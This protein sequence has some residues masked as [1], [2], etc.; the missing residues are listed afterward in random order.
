MKRGL[1]FLA[2]L[3]IGALFLWLSFRHVPWEKLWVYMQG[4]SFGWILPFLV[5]ALLSHLIRA[6][7]WKMLIERENVK[8]DLSD[9]YAAV[10]I[11][12][13]VNYAVPRLGEISRCIYVSRRQDQSTSSLIGTVIVERAVDLLFLLLAIIF[14]VGY[15][16]TDPHTIHDLFGRGV[17]D[18]FRNEFQ[19]ANPLVIGSLVA[20]VISVFF[21]F[22]LIFKWL[23][24]YY[25]WMD[26]I[27][28]KGMDLLR[29]VWDGI[30]GIS[31]IQNWPLFLLLSLL[32]WFCYVLM[33]YIPFSMFHM[34]QSYHLTLLDA[35][36]ITVI[37]SIGLT[38]PTP[39]GMG[40]Y[41]WFVKQALWV[42]YGIPQ[43]TG[44][45]YAFI[46]YLTAMLMFM[47]FTPIIVF[48]S[49][50]L[51]SE[52]EVFVSLRKLLKP[53]FKGQEIE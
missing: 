15:V 49:R 45:A 11:G 4:M 50:A 38:L 35:L 5:I 33:T 19:S 16:V 14:V 3:V 12:Y 32:M 17:F 43:V 7:R 28:I 8:V 34:I 52:R 18:W 47:V 22:Y 42:L 1:Q 25:E 24:Q 27:R 48:I 37:A 23:G 30:L 44:L 2:S 6:M 20:L 51:H 31:R 26:R 13:S 9:L 10:M 41:H 40:T 46:T 39:G 21:L 36:T 29:M 53:P